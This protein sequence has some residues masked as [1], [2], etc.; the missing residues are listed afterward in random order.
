MSVSERQALLKYPSCRPSK[1]KQ[2]FVL[3][4]IDFTHMFFN[5]NLIRSYY[6]ITRPSTKWSFNHMTR[7]WLTPSRP[8][9]IFL[10][11]TLQAWLYNRCKNYRGLQSLRRTLHRRRT[12]HLWRLSANVCP[13]WSWTLRVRKLS[14]AVRWWPIEWKRFSATRPTDNWTG[15]QNC[16]DVICNIGL[17]YFIRN[18]FCAT[19]TCTCIQLNFDS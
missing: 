12:V 17:I 13:T 18:E 10:P 11:C 4:Y 9:V 16:H 14:P 19:N 15:K 2:L 3:S 6:L 5:H 7:F 8:L 1:Y